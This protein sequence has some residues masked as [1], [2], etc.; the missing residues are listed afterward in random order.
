MVGSD[1]DGYTA[2][3]HELARLVPHML[4][5]ESQRVNYYIRGLAPEIKP[6]VTLSEP[7][8][9]QGAVS[10]ANCLTTDEIKD[11]LFRKKENAGNKK[12]SNDQ[13][14]NRGIDD[15]N[16]IQRTGGNFALTVPEKG[17]GQHQYACQHPK[18]ARCNF[19]HSG[20]CPVCHRCNQ[21]GH[22]TRTAPIEL[23]IKDQGQLV[24]SVEILTTLGGIAQG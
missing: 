23:L 6:H 1:I 13:N 4:T 2:R 11:G 19:Y 5:P 14:K 8:T 18:C 20:N 7:A 21:V 16:K 15:R 24:M 3:F 22:F 12:R 9:I 17:Q 10:M